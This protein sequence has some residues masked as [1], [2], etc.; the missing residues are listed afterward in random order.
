MKL[1]TTASALAISALLSTSGV[2]TAQSVTFETYDTDG[3]GMLSRKEWAQASEIR[4][5]R[6]FRMASQGDRF[7]TE[8]EFAEAIDDSRL[9]LRLA[10]LRDKVKSDLRPVFPP[11]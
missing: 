7:I 11:V 5:K 10:A 2:A 9:T 3:D 6:I 4:S 8:E 1:L